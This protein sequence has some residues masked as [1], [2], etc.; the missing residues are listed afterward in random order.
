MIRQWEKWMMITGVLCVLCFGISGCGDKDTA[1]SDA[2]EEGSV[3]TPVTEDEKV[4]DRTEPDTE[5][6]SPSKEAQDA[7][8]DLGEPDLIGDIKEIDGAQ[9]TVVEAK[10]E[11]MED[12]DIMIAPSADGDDSDFEKVVV[13]CD[14]KTIFYTRTIYD[15][16][17]RCEDSDAA[18]EDLAAGSSVYVWGSYKED[19]L[20][21]KTIQITEV[22]F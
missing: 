21:A 20:Y 22:V 12:G 17:K 6:E 19:V 7:E 2:T 10:T 16:G 1:K 15:G 3:V 18:I 5:D 8:A 14:E 11:E 9:F 13:V 4:Q